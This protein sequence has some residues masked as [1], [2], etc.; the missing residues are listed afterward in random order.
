MSSKA[1]PVHEQTPFG[2]L[3][4][5][6]LHGILGYQL[7][8]ATITTTRV[9]GERVG[10]PFELRPVEF[11]ILT[12]VHENPGVSARQLADAL[13]VTP[14]NITMWIDKLERR[15]LIERERSTIDRRAQHIRPTVEGAKLARQAVERVIEGEQ[16]VLAVLSPAERA[17][18]IELLHKVA[19]CRKR[20]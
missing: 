7:A 5:A 12:L 17:M 8:Q 16:A 6:G 9:F 3:D 11:T 14:P 18:L 4:E 2:R 19:R 1:A 15:G 13:A 20:G 10:A